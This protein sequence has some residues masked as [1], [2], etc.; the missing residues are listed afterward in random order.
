MALSAEQGNSLGLTGRLLPLLATVLIRTVTWTVRIHCE[1]DKVLDELE[2]SGR[3]AVVAFFHGRQFLPTGFLIGR[4]MGIMSSL[5]R[6]GELQTRV[7]TG[8]GYAV[9]R[10]SASRSGARGL[11]GLKKLMEKGY[12]ATFAVDGPKGP[13][14][15][16]KPG[17][18]YLAKKTGAPIVGLA[19][20]A[21]PA[22]IF[23]RAWDRYLLPW[24]FSRGAVIF[25][26]PVYL[27]SDT[28]EEAMLRDSRTLQEELLRLQKRADEMVGLKTSIQKTDAGNM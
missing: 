14:H 3:N 20:S 19:A 6:D 18:V 15:E 4:K 28:S 22:H 1:G 27:D 25:G 5:S 17:A 12:H 10:G 11:I 21:K 16:V 13:I 8:L 24:P 2:S 7:M 9:V 23:T 26:D